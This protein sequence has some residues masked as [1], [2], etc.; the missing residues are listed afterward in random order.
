MNSKESGSILVLERGTSLWEKMKEGASHFGFPV[1]HVPDPGSTV[2][3][4][5]ALNPHLAV[6]GPSLDAQA[7][8][9][10]VH[11]L[12]IIDPVTPVLKPLD[13]DGEVLEQVG[14]TACFEHIYPVA[15]D[16]GFEEVLRTVGLALAQR[17]ELGPQPDFPIL[18]GESLGMRSI[19]RKICS[20]C[21]KD[22]TVLI[23][24][25]TGTGKDLIA[26]SIHFHSPRK[27][28]PLIKINCGSL[29]DELL[30]SE[31]FGF[32]KGAFTDAHRA[33]PGRIELAHEGTLFVDEIGNL[34]LSMQVKFLQ[35]LEDKTFS[36]LGAT[37]D[38][39][40]NAR[41]V[42]AT[43]YDLW[44][45]VTEGAFRKDLFYRLN[46]IHI[47]AP[48]LRERKED[49]P[50]LCHYFMHKYC[51]DFKIER[52][53]L[54]RSIAEVFQSYYWPG[55]VRELENVIRRAIVVRDWGF[56]FKE[57]DLEEKNRKEV[58]QDSAGK[59]YETGYW[60]DAEVARFFEE[61]D[62]SLKKIIKLQA[63]EAERKAILAALREVRWNRKKAA[64]LLQVSYK[65][66]LNRIVELRIQGP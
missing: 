38:K 12:K 27:K 14:K 6:L 18:V 7:V 31:V 51:F 41:V 55:N 10:S 43:N 65:T 50:L 2:E 56:I 58:Q 48:A 30:E 35:I 34:S 40:I 57:L 54:P 13:R 20:V 32:Q 49:I 33:K 29:P 11:K 59:P 17:V 26:R 53:E 47:K 5:N 8:S 66:L 52:L 24:G 64:E 63:S 9:E 46:V 4:L 3:Q 44:Q 16:Q 15:F 19:R 21:D 22:I 60:S 25:E 28:G 1:V 62:F 37:Q 42:V 61:K 23:T 39:I 45:K 36:R